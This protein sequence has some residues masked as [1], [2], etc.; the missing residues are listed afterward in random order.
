M[1]SRKQLF[2]FGILTIAFLACFWST[3]R[4]LVHIWTGDGDYSYAPLIPLIT[5]YLLWE[6]R[7]EIAATPIRTNW[8]AGLMLFLFLVVSA[9]GILGSSPSAVRPAMP[10]VILCL[11][12]FCFGG[13]LFRILAFPLSLLFFMV[14]LPTSVQTGIGLPLRSI[15]TKLGA[16][17]L[18]VSGVPAFVEGNVIDLGVTQLQVVEACSGLRYILPLLALGV[19]YAYFFEKVRW[20]QF[21]L[22]AFTIPVSIL[23]N[24]FRIGITGILTQRFGPKAAEGFFHAFS[25]WFVFMF[26]FALLFL[27]HYLMKKLF[28]D[29]TGVSSGD[30]RTVNTPAAASAD[31]RVPVTV[32]AALLFLIGILGFST[33]S[34]PGIGLPGGFA[35]FPMGI[36]NW[37]GE[38]TGVIA[39]DIIEQSGAEEAFNANYNGEKGGSISLYIGYR[40]A[41]FLESENFFHSP[42]VCI[43]SSGWKVISTKAH[44]IPGM[45][46]FGALEVSEMMI[47][48]MGYRQL[49]Y[50]WFQTKNRM[51]HDV[52]INRYHLSL[53]AIAR[54]NTYDLFIRPITPIN[55]DEKIEDAE[56]RMDQFVRD[57]MPALLQFLKQRQVSA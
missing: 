43:P 55:R 35:E 30:T 27:F 22:A 31:N 51:S 49:V 25:G 33:A 44:Q 17:M 14:P 20:K 39:R 54:D 10:F 23:T 46:N 52:N 45:E 15:S 41:P 18:S 5:G 37:K 29:K 32:S 1:T 57:M 48:K 26:A 2:F 7:K 12:L 56:R 13:G 42:N 3:L 50:F 6:R 47:E 28:R 16:L 9:Y 40:G 34:L 19:I 38:R 8:A 24:G 53:H 11:T 4:G 36:S 21:L